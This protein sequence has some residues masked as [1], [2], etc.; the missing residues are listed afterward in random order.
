MGKEDYKQIL[1]D[2]YE[3]RAGGIKDDKTIE[4]ALKVK[5][6]GKLG[7]SE[8]VK[9]AKDTG[10]YREDMLYGAAGDVVRE[11]LTER[12]L[13]KSNNQLTR[14]QAEANAREYIDYMREM[15]REKQ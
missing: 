3:L 15:H 10:K 14:Q 8:T 12:F 1:S 7:I 6:E 13:K 2:S 11:Q 5:D 4:A 9:I